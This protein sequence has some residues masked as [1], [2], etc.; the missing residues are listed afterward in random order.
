[1]RVQHRR[2]NVLLNPLATEEH[3]LLV[4]AWAE[5][6]VARLAGEG[7]QKFS[8]TAFSVNPTRNLA[9]P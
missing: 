1:M 5:A 9:N 4:T 7:V 3:A 6:E 8:D 2:K